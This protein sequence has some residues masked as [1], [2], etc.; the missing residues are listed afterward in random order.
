[1]SRKTGTLDLKEFS[2][3][4]DLLLTIGFGLNTVFYLVKY[5]T[6]YL[7]PVGIEARVVHGI[8]F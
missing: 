8:Q 7:V 4:F 6:T 1:M 2:T 5:F 3:F